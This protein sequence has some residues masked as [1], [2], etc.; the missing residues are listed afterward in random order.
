MTLD[1]R[2]VADLF[3]ADDPDLSP[4]EKE[5]VIRFARDEDRAA[6]YTAEA[7]LGRRLLKHPHAEVEG[8][9]VADGSARPEVPVEDLDG[10][11]DV[12]GVR[13]TAPV[14]LLQVKGSPR[15]SGG[16]ADIVTDRVLDA[17]AIAD[18][19]ERE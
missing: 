9:T 1:E 13:A 5:T 17:D 7:G 15:R 18:G 19:G 14:G 12:V 8:V 4:A 11:E 2:D 6:V 16:H 10:D 3:T